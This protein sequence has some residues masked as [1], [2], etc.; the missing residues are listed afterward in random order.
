M[1]AVY[2]HYLYS[3]YFANKYYYNFIIKFCSKYYTTMT[4][5]K[6]IGGNVQTISVGIVNYTQIKWKTWSLKSTYL[7]II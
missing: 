2:L 7:G 5:W 6:H 4:L 3:M 1:L